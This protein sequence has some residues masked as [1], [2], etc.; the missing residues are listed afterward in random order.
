MDNPVYTWLILF[1]VAIVLVGLPLMI[2]FVR[3][4]KRCPSNRILVIYG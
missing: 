3:R 2:L 1:F 4:Y